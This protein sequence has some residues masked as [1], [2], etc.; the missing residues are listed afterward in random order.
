MSLSGENNYLDNLSNWD[1]SIAR[2]QAERWDINLTEEHLE[3]L[4]TARRFYN[5]YGFS[6]SMRPLTKFV[7]ESLQ[8]EKGRSIYLLTLFPGASAMLIADI[9]GIPKPRN[10]L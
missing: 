2:N 7:S 1:E 4:H 10:C 5:I 8:T 3:I 6:P 9:A